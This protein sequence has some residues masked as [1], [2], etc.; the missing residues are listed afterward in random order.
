LVEIALRQCLQRRQV[1][2]NIGDDDDLHRTPSLWRTL[3]A[4]S[5]VCEFRFCRGF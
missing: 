5:G 1:G 2:M 4:T 3:A